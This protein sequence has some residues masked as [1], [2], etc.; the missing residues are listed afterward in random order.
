MLYL[1]DT[2]IIEISKFKKSDFDVINVLTTASD[3]KYTNEI[4][5]FLS[6]QWEDPSDEFVRNIINEVYQ[7]IKT[8]KA[9]NQ[10]RESAFFEF[11]YLHLYLAHP[12]QF[13]YLIYHQLN[14]YQKLHFHQTKSQFFLLH[15]A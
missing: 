13:S 9:L 11:I 7:G 3:L 4:K 12:D 1:R 14:L 15:L 6:K 10:Y 5:Q 2:Q 8:K